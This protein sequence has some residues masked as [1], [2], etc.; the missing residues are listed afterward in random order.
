MNAAALFQRAIPGREL[1]ETRN[2]AATLGERSTTFFMDPSGNA[3]EFKA[4][5]DR[6]QIFA[7]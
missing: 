6:S 7:K 4:G 2:V 1:K 5:V 3:L